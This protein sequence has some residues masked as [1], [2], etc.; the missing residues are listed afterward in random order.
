M[1]AVA[2][3]L[4]TVACEGSRRHFFRSSSVGCVWLISPPGVGIEFLCLSSLAAEQ[5]NRNFRSHPNPHILTHHRSNAELR[6]VGIETSR[7]E[8]LTEKPSPESNN[9]AMSV[10][11][12][13]KD[14]ISPC[15]GLA[16]SLT[17][18]CC[19]HIKSSLQ[20]SPWSHDRLQ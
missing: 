16:P 20:C 15:V 3:E 17:V 7:T 12:S 2:C 13:E 14:V 6:V 19:S 4:D 8:S 1:D 5:K 11:A 9:L 10:Y 18:V